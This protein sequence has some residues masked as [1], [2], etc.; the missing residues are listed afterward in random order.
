[1]SISI[2]FD[3]EA[4]LPKY[5]AQRAAEL[6]IEKS[7]LVLTGESVANKAQKRREFTENLVDFL[8]STE[9]RQYL[10]N[11]MKHAYK[12]APKD[13]FKK[14]ISGN[15]LSFNEEY[16]ETICTELSDKLQLDKVANINWTTTC[17]NS[18]FINF[19]NQRFPCWTGTLTC[20]MLSENNVANKALSEGKVVERY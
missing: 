9:K 5:M 10:A 18:D 7:G 4:R 11:W 14:I 19:V 8:Y 13:H 17:K 1:M 16:T 6:L 2:S 15:I 12:V 3:T 20:F